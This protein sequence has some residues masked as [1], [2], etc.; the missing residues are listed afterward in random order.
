MTKELESYERQL[1]RANENIKKINN[2][3]L[4]NKIENINKMQEDKLI[5]ELRKLK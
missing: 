5:K 4:S 3:L 1:I 2:N